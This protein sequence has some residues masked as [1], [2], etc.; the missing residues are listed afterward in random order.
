MSLEIGA[1]G[2]EVKRRVSAD[3]GKKESQGNGQKRPLTDGSPLTLISKDLPVT[4]ALRYYNWFLV[5]LGKKNQLSGG[6]KQSLE[7]G[8]RM[9][10]GQSWQRQKEAT[11]WAVN[12]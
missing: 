8:N 2:L 12:I 5:D 3:L 1:D 9:L 4:A 6:N 10:F 7:K 11:H